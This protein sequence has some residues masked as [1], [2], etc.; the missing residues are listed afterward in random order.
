MGFDSLKETI[1]KSGIPEA[2]C[3]RAGVVIAII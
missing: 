2:L 3:D 1:A